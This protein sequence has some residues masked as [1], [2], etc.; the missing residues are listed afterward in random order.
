MGSEVAGLSD[1]EDAT[2]A[3]REALAAATAALE[4]QSTRFGFSAHLMRDTTGRFILLDAQAALVNGLAAMG[5][6]DREDAR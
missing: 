2:I 1:L 3:L 4:E 5:R 6:A